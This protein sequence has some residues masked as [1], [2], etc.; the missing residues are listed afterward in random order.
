MCGSTLIRDGVMLRYLPCS[1]QRRF[2]SLPSSF[3]L[4][5]T[6]VTKH[7]TR[8]LM[9]DRPGPLARP[10]SPVRY[11]LS[12]V[13]GPAPCGPLP[14]SCSFY[15]FP[16]VRSSFSFYSILFHS[17]PFSARDCSRSILL[18]SSLFYLLLLASMFTRDL[19]NSVLYKL[20]YE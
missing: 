9:T 19:M 15:A 14:F 11:S 20:L 3:L 18:I 17:I 1:T 4:Y 8:D 5:D 6:K 13:H 16:P 12:R 7:D 2:S 10:R